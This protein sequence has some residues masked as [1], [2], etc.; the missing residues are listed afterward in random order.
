IDENLIRIVVIPVRQR[1]DQR[2]IVPGLREV[3][4]GRGGSVFLLPVFQHIHQAVD[5]THFRPSAAARI[6]SRRR[7][8]SSFIC[9][10]C[11]ASPAVF[12]CQSQLTLRTA[13]VSSSVSTDCV[14]VIC[15]V[16]FR[17]WA[18]GSRPP[19]LLM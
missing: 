13:S 19:L 6:N 3:V 8:F 17:E 10:A 14:A 15:I 2:G 4:A 7:S 18:N 16:P 1:G 9:P 5:K 12:I 11:S